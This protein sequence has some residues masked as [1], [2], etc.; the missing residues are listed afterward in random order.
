MP[1]RCPSIPENDIL[2]TEYRHMIFDDYRVVFRVS[3]RAVHVLRVV[4]GNRLLDT[5]YFGGG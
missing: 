1:E 5:S 3:G 4:H 2:G